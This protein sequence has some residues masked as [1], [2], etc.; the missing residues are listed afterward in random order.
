[1]K[2]ALVN[3]TI[4]PYFK[5]G[6][7]KRV[8]E[9]AKLLVQKGHTV[10][11]FGMKYWDGEDV[12]IKD[13]VYLHGVCPAQELYIKG[14]RSIKQAIYFAY[15]LL[16]PLLKE[17]IDIVD[18][19]N[20][21]YFP[22]FPAKLHSLM[23][24][25]ILVITWHEVWNDYWYEYLGKKGIFGQWIE[26]L[27]AGLSKNMITVSETTKR[28]LLSIGVRG[29]ITTVPNGVDFEEI[30][31]A[32]PADDQSD[33]I[34]A[35]R[36]IK[37]KNVDLLIKS[38]SLIKQTIPNIKC[39]IIGDGP[40]RRHLEEIVSS[41]H[42]EQNVSF[43]GFIKSSR[44]VFSRLKASKVFVLPSTREGFGIALLEA[45]AC[46]LPVVTVR[47]PQNA[48][49]DLVVDG[50]N[51]FLCELNEA[52]MSSKIM[53]A[54]ERAQDMSSDCVNHAKQYSW[55]NAVDM[56]EDTYESILGARA[57]K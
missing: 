36:L 35:G 1:M 38:I 8:W 51:G 16:G 33:I 14:R 11:L 57:G 55:E 18:C 42:L 53:M 6:A 15:K 3:D 56:I 28:Q 47:H 32:H 21:P 9:I 54:L 41:T 26:R 46:G 48:A 25:S 20:F 34:F 19:S 40:E 39:L 29:N 22:C 50:K 23:K 13:G 10:H 5:G 27:V 52:D 37:D 30:D 12:I 49:T 45:N 43:L 17:D 44:D 31:T 7:P 24:G 2:I 4:Y